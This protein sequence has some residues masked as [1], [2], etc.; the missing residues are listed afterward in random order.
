MAGAGGSEGG[1]GPTA[2]VGE[3]TPL[4]GS[5]PPRKGKAAALALPVRTTP[6]RER[7]APARA[8]L[9]AKLV[10]AAEDARAKLNARRARDKDKKKAEQQKKT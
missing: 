2:A 3:V 4:L 9:E 5:A 1:S 7:R 6:K 8:T 10:Q